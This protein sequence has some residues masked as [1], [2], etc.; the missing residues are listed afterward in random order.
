MA[1]EHLDEVSLGDRG[2]LWARTARPPVLL[3]AAAGSIVNF[4]RC[5][6]DSA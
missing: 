2:Q 3:P 1:L 4:D 5:A 6:T